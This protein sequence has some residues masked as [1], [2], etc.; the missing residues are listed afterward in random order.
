MAIQWW[1]LYTREE[2]AEL[3]VATQARLIAVYN[4]RMKMDAVVAKAQADE[5]RDAHHQ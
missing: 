1:N 2:F 3:P 4:L 5:I